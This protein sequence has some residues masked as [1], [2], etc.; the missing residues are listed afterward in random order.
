MPQSR[1]FPVEHGDD[2]GFGR[3]EYQIVAAV[4]A[5]HDSNSPFVARP[6]MFEPGNQAVHVRIPACPEIG[7]VLLG[8][9][10]D[11]AFDIAGRAAEFG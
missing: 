1:K 8:Q 4:I 11:L 6:G 10:L 2:P 3:M 9:A 7:Y 5:M